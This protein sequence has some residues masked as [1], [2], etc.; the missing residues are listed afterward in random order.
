M[1]ELVKIENVKKIYQTGAVRFEA[2]KGITLPVTAGD[3]IA[4]MGHSGSGKSTLPG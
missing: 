1:N 4:I 3:F 2:L